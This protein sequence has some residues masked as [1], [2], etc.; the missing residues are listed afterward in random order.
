MGRGLWKQMETCQNWVIVAFS[1]KKK[2]RTI[3]IFFSR[4]IRCEKI[5]F[6][7]TSSYLDDVVQSWTDDD[8]IPSF[9]NVTSGDV[10]DDV[11]DENDTKRRG[12]VG[13][14]QR[15]SAGFSKRGWRILHLRCVR[16]AQGKST[17]PLNFKNSV[18]RFW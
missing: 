1:Q 3:N 11:D 18:T 5:L 4:N 8:R 6:S 13:V 15:I 14:V 12:G 9:K 10:N 2:T 7:L 16:S 17:C